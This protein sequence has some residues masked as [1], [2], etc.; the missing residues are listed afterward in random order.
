LQDGW[1]REKVSIV[2]TEHAFVDNINPQTTAA[3]MVIISVDT[4]YI[5]TVHTYDGILEE[6]KKKE[7]KRRKKKQTK[8]QKKTQKEMQKEMPKEK[9][10]QKKKRR[11]RKEK[12]GT[13]FPI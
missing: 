6:R 1:R 12:R 4:E 9:K 10:K 2:H 8:M 7:K 13:R 5:G 3:S 11:R